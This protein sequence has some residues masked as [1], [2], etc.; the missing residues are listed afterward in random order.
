MTRS[1]RRHQGTALGSLLFLATLLSPQAAWAQLYTWQEV[2]GNFVIKNAPPPWYKPG[3]RTRGPRVQVLRDGKVIDD[4]DWPL[5]KRQESRVNEARQESERLQAGAQGLIPR[6]LLDSGQL[7][8]L[9]KSGQLPALPGTPQ[10]M[11]QGATPAG[12]TPNTPR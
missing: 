5:D 6:E 1:S 10:K 3:E 2:E 4:T 8:A 12:P 9:L 7:P 11:P